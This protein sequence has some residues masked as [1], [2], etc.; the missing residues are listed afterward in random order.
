LK[1]S[2]YYL[3]KKFA[4]I[5]KAVSVMNDGDYKAEEIDKFL[6]VLSLN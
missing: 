5:Q 4:K 1:I 6:H 3:I 2:L